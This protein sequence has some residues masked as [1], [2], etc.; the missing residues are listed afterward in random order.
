MRFIAAIIS[1]VIAFGLIAY[2][3]AQRTVLAE[4][5][6]ITASETFTTKAPVTIVN[7]STLKS[8]PGR[9]EIRISGAKKIF[10]AYG[11]TD[12][13]LAW[14]GDASYNRVGFN[15]A[16][17]TLTSRLVAGKATE[18]P[19][20]QGSDLWLD[21]F[22]ETDSLDFTVNVPDNISVIIVSDGTSAAPSTLSIRWP[23]DNRTPWSGPLIVGGIVLLIVGLALYLW[24]LAHLRRSRGP[25]RKTPKM[26]KVPRQRSYRPR[27]PKA[28]APTGSRR[29]T[30]RRMVAIV[31]VLLIGGLTLSGC[32][33]DSW[34]DF[35]P[36]AASA[37]PTPTATAAAAD[38]SPPAVTVPQ[39]RVILS[40]ISAVAAKA[41]ADKDVEL[42][43]T[44]FDGAALDLRA[45]N[46]AI[47][48]VDDTQ[49]AL[50]AIPASSAT[51]ILPQLQDAGKW[52][53]VVFTVVQNPTDK[54]VPPVGLMLEQKTARSD[55]KV[56]YATALEAGV[57]LPK[58]AAKEIGAPRLDPDVKLLELAPSKIALAYGDILE[59]GPTSESA[60]YFDTSNDKL[61]GLIGLEY[62]KSLQAAL[63]A[64]AK[65]EFA[66]SV[67]PYDSISLG[68]NDSG[69]IVAVNLNET[70]TVTP[71]EAGA[72]VNPEGQVKSLSG[73]TGSTKGTVAV[74]SDQL[75]FYV[76]SSTS[77]EKI[78]LLGF[79]TGL[80]SAKELP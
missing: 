57:V 10:A 9:Q 37:T 7:S 18:V 8:L 78:S 80:T 68:S 73:V 58:L 2:G 32:T 15:K 1:F 24:G 75:L 44:R 64:T 14:V 40:R 50:A 12:D 13:V 60:K 43:K 52:P 45:A 49:A 22:S 33:P 21:E 54:K 16:K 47:R 25:R 66:N 4:A 26:P 62:R 71:V 38:V 27:K 34:P 67:G 55:Y 30:R 31:P 69:A 23:L 19:N 63:P 28:L 39:L 11:R 35:G 41:D 29:S 65:M 42:A 17:S 36:G 51:V 77:T 3:I 56:E 59:K 20:P 5:D 53:R 74:Y 61:I 72:A 70:V 79:A 46:Y 48:K 6:S 76:P